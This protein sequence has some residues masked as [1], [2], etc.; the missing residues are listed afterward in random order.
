[1]VSQNLIVLKRKF[2]YW[3]TISNFLYIIVL[4]ILA[5]V[6]IATLTGENGILTQANEAKEVNQKAGAEEKVGLEVQGSYDETGKI[7][8]ETL[9][10][11]LKNIEGLT[12]SGGTIEDNPISKL[13]A[14]VVVDENSITIKENGSVVLS[15]WQQT[16]Y[17]ITNGEIT[18]N[19]GDVVNYNELS[20][21]SKNSEIKTEE[22]GYETKQTLTTEDLGWRV[23]GIGENGGI[24]LISDKATTDTIILSGETGFLN[25]E[26]IL[27]SSCNELYGKGQY[28]ESARSLKA[29]DVVK[30]S[31]PKYNKEVTGDY[32]Q[33]W[34]FRFPEIG[35]YLQ[36]RYSTDNGENW[37]DWKDITDENYQTYKIPGSNE[38]ISADNRIES[39]IIKNNG[40]IFPTDTYLSNE[41]IKDLLASE[42]YILANSWN[43]SFEGSWAGD[44]VVTNFR[45]AQMLST[46]DVMRGALGDLYSSKGVSDTYG[47]KF[48][49]VV[50]LKSD[51]KLSGT[52]EEGWTI[53]E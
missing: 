2:F 34:Q 38:A 10:D 9:N 26:N 31:D 47:G 49:P 24:E 7:N 12:H 41:K 36:Y 46:Y 29:E 19:V 14:T 30:L 20:N 48:R 27:N 44:F 21:G 1:M 35:D 15:E 39:E 16:G 45:F 8:I 17:Q 42:S 51:I 28:A 18:L 43:Y 52:S 25:I 4:L 11:N 6:S 5:G 53:T 40:Y 50:S 13:P 3:L 23:L 22:S 33:L 37:S 32:G